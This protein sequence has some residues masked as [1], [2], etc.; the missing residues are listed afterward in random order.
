MSGATVLVAIVGIAGTL[1]APLVSN[2]GLERRMLLKHRHAE[3]SRLRRAR[4]RAYRT[5][6]DAAMACRDSSTANDAG[7]HSPQQQRELESAMKSAIR[8]NLAAYNSVI[9]FGSDETRRAARALWEAASKMAVT[10]WNTPQELNT[11]TLC[12][13]KAEGEFAAAARKELF[14]NDVSDT[15]SKQKPS[16]ALR[17][18]PPKLNDPPNR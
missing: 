13:G 16:D 12:V 14:P 5:M 1:A 18:E 4:I 10:C 6:L 7:P 15:R 17:T 8:T 2:W 9:L 11:L 3:E